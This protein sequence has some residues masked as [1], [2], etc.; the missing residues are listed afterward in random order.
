MAVRSGGGYYESAEV[1]ATGADVAGDLPVALRDLVVTILS[2]LLI[3]S[4][5]LLVT[6]FSISQAGWGLRASAGARDSGVAH[7]AL[8]VH[9]SASA[10][11]AVGDSLEV[12][13]VVAQRVLLATHVGHL[14]SEEALVV[15]MTTIVGGPKLV[16]R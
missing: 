7:I 9:V 11:L 16:V 4:L 10:G 13:S 8:E 5:K 14:L 1:D 3:L 2:T 6:L 12:L 15:S